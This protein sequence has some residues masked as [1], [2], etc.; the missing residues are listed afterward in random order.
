MGLLNNAP[1]S[2]KCPENPICF[3]FGAGFLCS[4]Q[5]PSS[6]AKGKTR[7]K[8]CDK[9]LVEGYPGVSADEAKLKF[10]TDSLFKRDFLG[11]VSVVEKKKPKNF[12]PSFFEA[13]S[14]TS[15]TV[16]RSFIFMEPPD[17]EKRFGID[18]K[19][20]QIPVDTLVDDAGRRVSGILMVDPDCPHRR[21]RVPYKLETA[22]S[23][24]LLQPE[25][26][27]RAM[28]GKDLQSYYDCDA[29]KHRPAG[30]KNPL[31]IEELQGMVKEA[32]AAAEKAATAPNEEPESA[33]NP[34]EGMEVE[35]QEQEEEDEDAPQ[36]VLLPSEKVRQEKEKKRGRDGR[37]RPAGKGSKKGKGSAS[38]GPASLRHSLKPVSPSKQNLLRLTRTSSHDN[39]RSTS[40]QI[41]DAEST[42]GLTY[43]TNLDESGAK[44]RKSMSGTS[45]ASV[46][47]TSDSAVEKYVEKLS[48]ADILAGKKMGNELSFARRAWK[49]MPDKDVAGLPLKTHIDL[50]EDAAKIAAD[51]L[52][53]INPDERDAICKKVLST[54][55]PKDLPP[56]FC[57]AYTAA[58]AK[59]MDVSDA[60]SM[61]KWFEVV[62]PGQHCESAALRTWKM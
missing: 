46:A 1:S 3:Q 58:I 56:A 16:E 19:R 42:G 45:S 18:P 38:A 11:A 13:S 41:D 49:A 52:Q 43:V 33:K 60:G 25:A 47:G 15:T 51:K 23:E 2:R 62:Y 14:S 12:A 32:V 54:M 27:M 37:G 55:S 44:R 61:K 29:Q 5:D 39:T 48:I 4:G 8:T 57:S 24:K 17:F 36:G 35:E 50:A 26:C 10:N 59:E 20:A 22:L 40:S 31:T 7:C 30:V 53:T 21:V 6:F 34:T 9:V 28:Q